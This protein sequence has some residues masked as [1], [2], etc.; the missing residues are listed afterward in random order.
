MAVILVVEDDAFIREC[1]VMHF[2][3]L[4]DLVLAA[5]DVESALT[6]LRR[7]QP[8]D[9]LFTDIYLR[10]EVFGGCDLARAA[11]LLRPDLRV[12]YTT[13]NAATQALRALFVSGSGFISKPYT[14]NQLQTSVAALLAAGRG[15]SALEEEPSP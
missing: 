12:L 11:I 6:A 8:I 15:E 3:D 7:E 4:G 9:V 14:P 13:G 10:S 2:E 1:A 5:S